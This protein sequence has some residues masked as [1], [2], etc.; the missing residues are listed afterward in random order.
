MNAVSNPL[1]T[2]KRK[3]MP[4]AIAEGNADGDVEGLMML[5]AVRYSA[6]E[7]GDVG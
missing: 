2:T 6:Y 7:L 3:P 5:G 1:A 4:L